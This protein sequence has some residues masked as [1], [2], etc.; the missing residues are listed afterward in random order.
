MNKREAQNM[1]EEFSLTEMNRADPANMTDMMRKHTP[2]I[3]APAKVKA[4]EPFTV[5]IKVGGIDGV[6]HPNVLGHWIN[7]VAL[8][9]GERS[10]ARVEFA[11]A[12]SQPQT[13][14]TI[15]LE[16]SATLRVVECCNM[17]GVWESTKPVAV[18]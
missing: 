1:A 2:V 3:D 12:V 4:N 5:T 17:H 9:A 18:S 11:P 6:E 16:Q 7:W 10:L 13:T 8:Y 15:A 14:L